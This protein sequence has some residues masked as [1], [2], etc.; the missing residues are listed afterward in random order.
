VTARTSTTPDRCG[1]RGRCAC[2]CTPRSR[3]EGA[4]WLSAALPL[5]SPGHHDYHHRKDPEATCAQEVCRRP[6]GIADRRST[7]YAHSACDYEEGDGQ[8]GYLRHQLLRSEGHSSVGDG[9]AVSKS[10]ADELG[11][12]DRQRAAIAKHEFGTGV[13]DEQRADAPWTQ[14]RRQAERLPARMLVMRSAGGISC[15][16]SGRRS[17]GLRERRSRPART[18][19]PGRPTTSP[20]PHSEPGRA[21]RRWPGSRRWW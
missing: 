20:R 17:P 12:S 2:S 7:D 13:P 10:H 6:P 4:R 16:R 1:P 21:A 19:R 5:A 9:A 18:R 14:R 15:A 11:H 8:E 3:P